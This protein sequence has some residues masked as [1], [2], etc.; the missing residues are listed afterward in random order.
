MDICHLYT[1]RGVLLVWW[2]LLTAV[3]RVMVITRSFSRLPEDDWQVLSC[4]WRVSYL[5]IINS[6]VANFEIAHS[7]FK[8]PESRLGFV[9]A[10]GFHPHSI[11]ILYNDYSSKLRLCTA[12]TRPM[13]AL[14]SVSLL[15]DQA[16]RYSDLHPH[17][18]CTHCFNKKWLKE[19][20][21]TTLCLQRQIRSRDGLPSPI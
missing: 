10:N 18:F 4:G 2:A 1:R 16:L 11:Y 17:I 3:W 13:T 12:L 9:R 21:P 20:L 6:W 5:F 7:I 14:I 15:Q 19:R 8:N